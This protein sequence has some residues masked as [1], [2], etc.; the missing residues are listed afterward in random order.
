[1]SPRPQR[2]IIAGAGIAG[3]A[4]AVALH[5]AGFQARVFDR[6]NQLDPIGA[7]IQISPNATRLLDDL[8][9]LPR[10]LPHTTAPDCVEIRDAR[11]LKRLACIPLGQN[12]R[13][14]WGAQYLVCSRSA[15]QTALLDTASEAGVE[16]ET[17]TEVTDVD[18]RERD[19]IVVG[20]QRQG[21]ETAE[22][23]D[24]LIGADGVWSRLR[25][26]APEG[27]S[28][29]TGRIAWRATLPAGTPE[30]DAFAAVAPSDRVSAFA[31]P[32]FHL[33]AYPL[34]GGDINVVAIG[35]GPALSE[36]WSQAAKTRSVS[37]LL[38]EAEPRIAALAD[39]CEW[40]MWPLHIASPNCAWT[41][42]A[43]F[44]LVGDAAHAVSPFAAQGSAMAIEDAVTLSGLLSRLDLPDALAAY[45]RIRRPRMRRVATR[46]AL[47]QLAWNARGPIA[48]A[49]NL[50][51]RAKG[52]RRLAT[53]LDWLY[54]YDAREAL[55]RA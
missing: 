39:S 20:L 14:R 33:V 16:I 26:L 41:N 54:G 48:I 11:S 13:E 44:V 19:G 22:D 6:A 8:G 47:N 24:L 34:A 35:K 27:R 7:G 40:T 43:G 21:Q 23:A 38:N 4:T 10:L 46:S 29:F 49:R 17:G 52:D 1:M 36:D 53:D 2:I 30:R 42:P 25:A 31:H 32:R 9:V 18:F 51:F 28:I 50:V 37:E 55:L 3:L 5:R 15:L 12:A 45:E